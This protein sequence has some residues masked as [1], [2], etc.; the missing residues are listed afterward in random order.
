MRATGC[1]GAGRWRAPVR[2]TKTGMSSGPGCTVGRPSGR[3]VRI[4]LQFGVAVVTIAACGHVASTDSG[5][6]TATSPAAG[7]GSTVQSSQLGL[8]ALDNFVPANGAE[9]AQGAK[10]SAT[11]DVLQSNLIHSCMTRY[12]FTEQTG[13]GLSAA[14]LA[15]EDV[16]NSQFPDLSR[17][18]R[19]RSF[20]VG[21]G[22]K[23]PPGPPK[24][25]L[26]A[27]S[28]D[29][30]RCSAAARKPFTALLGAGGGLEQQWF[31]IVSAVQASPQERAK[32]A[33][34]AA[35]VEQEGTP[36]QWAASFQDFLAWT[37]GL[38]TRVTTD[39][40][41][42]SL[43]A[44]WALIFV[45]CAGPV[46]AMQDKLLAARRAG[47]LQQNYQQVRQVESLAGKVAMKVE[48]QA[49]GGAG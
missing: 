42:R 35:C 26:Q 32:L 5:P 36:R 43:N 15:S 14:V 28:S 38:G 10:F 31:S 22:F 21:T 44:H 48:R 12:G 16:D 30:K 9:W 47:F 18:V 41:R 49:A 4:G 17:I 45:R 1:N 6:A 34:F 8:E 2:R 23:T 7:S 29:S 20:D 46:V 27:F 33:G 19:T 39:A 25:Q 37:S 11:F 3:L 13:L 24:S 40:A